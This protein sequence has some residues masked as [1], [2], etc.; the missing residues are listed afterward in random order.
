MV[1]SGLWMKHYDTFILFN[2]IVLSYA[3]KMLIH[4]IDVM[5]QD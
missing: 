4:K 1:N 2:L 3:G 5:I